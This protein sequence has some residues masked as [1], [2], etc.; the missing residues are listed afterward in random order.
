MLNILLDGL[1]D[2]QFVGLVEGVMEGIIELKKR[3]HLQ[4]FVIEKNN[5]YG[6]LVRGLLKISKE[7]LLNFSIYK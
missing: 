4:S 1:D 3:K 2:G 5:A 6:A 7:V